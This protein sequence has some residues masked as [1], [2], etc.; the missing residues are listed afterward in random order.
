MVLGEGDLYQPIP[1]Q[2][3]V[4]GDNVSLNRPLYSVYYLR[5]TKRSNERK[6]TAHTM[7]RQ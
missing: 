6:C 2:V 5:L 3:K 4:N 1:L 7:T